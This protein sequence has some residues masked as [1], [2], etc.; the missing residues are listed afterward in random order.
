MP[1]LAVIVVLGLA[2]YRL[3]RLVAVDS[4]TEDVR[5]VVYRWAWIDDPDADVDPSPR[6]RVRPYLYELLTCPF[7]V[8]VW[9]SAGVFVVYGLVAASL[10]G[11]YVAIP[12]VA[13]V[14]ALGSAVDGALSE[15]AAS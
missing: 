5:A 14:A 12:A 8:G 4:L 2:A 9:T 6:G 11:W 1:D 10:A 15:V 13:G 7:C 3:A